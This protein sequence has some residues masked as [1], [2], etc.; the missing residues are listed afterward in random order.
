LLRAKDSPRKRKFVA[1]ANSQ[2]LIHFHFIPDYELR[3]RALTA[4]Q[5]LGP[6]GK[7]AIP[8]LT[9]L[10]DEP[11]AAENALLALLRMPGPEI[12]Q[13]L[14]RALTN[15]NKNVRMNAA[16][17]LALL[18]S[19]AA[20]AGPALIRSLRD[21]DE[22]VRGVKAGALGDVGADTVFAVPVLIRCLE[23]PSPVVRQHSAIAL[24]RLGTQAKAAVPALQKALKDSDSAVRL[25][26]RSALEKI[27]S[28]S[29]PKVSLDEPPQFHLDEHCDGYRGCRVRECG[30]TV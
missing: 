13:S 17:R 18:G 8:T 27:V 1:L 14:A 26:A 25:F 28:E 12:V 22:F 5:V 24:L 11:L 29:E 19:V 30:C 20:S 7:G 2:S 16:S 23:H 4:L 21:K 15:E 3:W 9:E 6:Q 10:L